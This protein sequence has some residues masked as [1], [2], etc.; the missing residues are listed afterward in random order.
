MCPSDTYKIYKSGSCVRIDT[1]LLGFDQSNWTR[2]SRSYIF[3]ALGRFIFLF[4]IRIKINA[5]FFF[6][7]TDGEA[8]FIEI[9]HD[10]RQA[11]IESITMLSE[12]ISE[13]L[14]LLKP[15]QEMI[16]ERL[17]SPTYITYFDTDKIT[18]E[19]YFFVYIYALKCIFL[20]KNAFC[21]I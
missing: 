11:Q 13:S 16:Q 8:Q 3:K 15:S 4:Y 2:G 6:I 12:P 17:N 21:W 18:F 19:R 10:L 1:T 5:S 14:D 9:N 20:L 7:Q